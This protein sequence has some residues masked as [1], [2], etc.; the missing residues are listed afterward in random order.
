M[1]GTMAR[2]P[3][4]DRAVPGLFSG[5]AGTAAVCGR[6]LAAAGVAVAQAPARAGAGVPL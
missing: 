4:T 3:V 6:T 1:M 5:G 2:V